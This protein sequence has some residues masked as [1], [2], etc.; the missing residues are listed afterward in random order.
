MTTTYDYSD[1]PV[2]GLAGSRLDKEADKDLYTIPKYLMVGSGISFDYVWVTES[3]DLIS[4][5]NNVPWG[6]KH[7]VLRISLEE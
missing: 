4:D 7:K 6:D 2:T 5:P 1:R 3:G